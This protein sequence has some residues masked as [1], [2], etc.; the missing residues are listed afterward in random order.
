MLFDF[1]R[2]LH[3]LG[4]PPPVC[5][6][7]AGR[8]ALQWEQLKQKRI[9]VIVLCP[10]DEIA[11]EFYQH[12]GCLMPAID[13][14][15]LTTQWFPTWEQSLYSPI[16]PSF[17]LERTSSC[18]WPKGVT[19]GLIPSKTLG[20]SVVE[21]KSSTFFRTIKLNRCGLNFLMIRL[22][23]FGPLIDCPNEP[24][25]DLLSVLFEFLPLEK[26]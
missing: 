19:C 25:Q 13:G 5:A 14:S 12:L 21:E 3:F 23:K 16:Q 6:L 4:T 8:S 15:D 18:S 2:P 20:L 11:N 22:K 9:P 7:L 1:T 26:F 24:F 10:N 17:H